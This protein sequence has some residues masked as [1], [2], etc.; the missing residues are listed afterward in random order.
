M[1]DI[2]PGNLAPQDRTQLLLLVDVA[3]IRPRVDKNWRVFLSRIG[4]SG[5][6]L[7]DNEFTSLRFIDECLFDLASKAPGAVIVQFADFKL[8]DHLSPD[9]RRELLRR[10][11]LEYGDP[12]K[13]FVIRT[14]KADFPLLYGRARVGGSIVSGDRFRDDHF[15]GLV[16]A[17]MPTF[18]HR[19]DPK[20]GE[21]RFDL[22]GD[23]G[24]PI[25]KWWD[26]HNGY[27]TGEWLASDDYA[28]TESLLRHQVREA[29]FEWHDERLTFNPSIAL[30]SDGQILVPQREPR[31][32]PLRERPRK[33]RASAA[34]DEQSVA[35]V[36]RAQTPPD[37]D[38]ASDF[39]FGFA[40]EK[41]PRPVAYL[42]A[43]E[44]RR[45]RAMVGEYVAVA[46]KPVTRNSVVCLGW[47][48]GVRPVVLSNAP[49][50][51]VSDLDGI[52][53]VCGY[54]EISGEEVRLRLEDDELPTQRTFADIKHELS[55]R[56]IQT[57]DSPPSGHEWRIVGF[58]EPLRF[59][60]NVAGRGRDSSVVVSSQDYEQRVG[61]TAGSGLSDD[62]RSALSA[63]RLPAEEKRPAPRV[64]AGGS[65]QIESRG[66]PR[67]RL[68]DEQMHESALPDREPPRSATEI[69][70][71][72]PRV[73]PRFLGRRAVLVGLAVGVVTAVAMLMAVLRSN[74]MGGVDEGQPGF[75]PAEFRVLEASFSLER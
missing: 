18:H 13:I 6:K 45:M 15:V 70:P 3:N 65:P 49:Q 14:A 51:S 1:A 63:E 12:A 66:N 10:S 16:P 37:L 29:T 31:I 59:L 61:S 48:T 47:T 4:L 7:R 11:R 73:H 22:H 26:E 33:R 57:V 32:R 64:V 60:R 55:R 21:F 50:L 72:A 58:P 28:E 44:H 67:R 34:R 8:Q 2:Q 23:P 71:G 53:E 41:R 20:T 43:D 38:G 17:G 40:G 74:E 42:L 36:G 24:F 35:P 5:L 69:E 19:I 39:E 30:D 46:G 27:V 75:S 68:P 52:V 9:D 56:R 25:E 54:V 62:G